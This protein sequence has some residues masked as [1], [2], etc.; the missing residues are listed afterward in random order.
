[1]QEEDDLNTSNIDVSTPKFLQKIEEEKI[2]RGRSIVTRSS[3]KNKMIDE[4]EDKLK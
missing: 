3:M 4:T 1:L 2:N